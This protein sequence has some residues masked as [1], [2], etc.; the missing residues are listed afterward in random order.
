MAGLLGSFSSGDYRPGGVDRSTPIMFMGENAVGAD[1]EALERARRMQAQGVPRE[2]IYA[3]T[4]SDG[5]TGWFLGPDGRWR[6]EI[7]DA[8]ASLNDEEFSGLLGGFSSNLGKL[9]NHPDLFKKYPQLAKVVARR[10]SDQERS[11]GLLGAFDSEKNEISLPSERSAALNTAL[12][13]IQHAIQ[14]A[15]K[16]QMG[17]DP[18]SVRTNLKRDA[19]MGVM[20][21]MGL[22]NQ[23]YINAAKEDSSTVEEVHKKYERVR[24]RERQINSNAQ[25]YEDRISSLQNGELSKL[26]NIELY[27]RLLGE[28]EARNVESRAGMTLEQLRKIYPWMT[29]DR[30]DDEVIVRFNR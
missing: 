30:K 19:L 1:L 3:S 8:G 6:F 13:E 7:S 27:K 25:K 14:K 12:H 20:N 11:E 29:Q 28:V 21:A 16:F 23:L 2:Q 18:D 22:V 4:A 17:S 5:K 9:I 10:L 24:E 26:P 15:E